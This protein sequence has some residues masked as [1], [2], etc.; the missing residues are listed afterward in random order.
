MIWNELYDFLIQQDG[1]APVFFLLFDLCEKKIRICI[2]RVYLK[3]IAK[4]Y[5]SFWIV[6][7]F[8][9]FLGQRPI[10]CLSLFWSTTRDERHR[11]KQDHDDSIFHCIT[12]YPL[13][14]VPTIGIQRC[15]SSEEVM[16]RIALS[17]YCFLSPLQ[18]PSNPQSE[19]DPQRDEPKLPHTIRERVQQQL[20]RKVQHNQFGSKETQA[21]D[22]SAHFRKKWED[23]SQKYHQ[24]IEGSRLKPVLTVK[25]HTEQDHHR[26]RAKQQVIGHWDRMN[27]LHP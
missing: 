15:G 26:D 8:K 9:I 11:D 12:H 6:A 14:R 21:R 22:V 10:L 13:L 24:I 16:S 1:V 27:R 17:A 20:K 23:H 4:G 18:P 3:D 7:G 5:P 19:Q 2:F 25:S